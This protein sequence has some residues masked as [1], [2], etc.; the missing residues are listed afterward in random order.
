VKAYL[1]NNIVSAIGKNDTPVEAAALD[2]LLIAREQGN[3]ELVTSGVTLGEIKRYEGPRTVEWI[4]RLLEKVPIVPWDKLL[5]F[6]NYGDRYTWISS[7]TIESDPLYV[8]L[9]ALGLDPNDAQHVF[10]AAKN[11]CDVF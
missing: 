3:V 11:G 6:H 2:R 10:V 7:P 8:A 5:G 1:D 9:L 4:F